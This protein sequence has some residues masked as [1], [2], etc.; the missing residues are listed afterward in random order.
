MSMQQDARVRPSSIKIRVSTGDG[1]DIV[2]SDG[3]AS[4]YDFPYLRDNCPCATCNDERE[5]KEREKAGGLRSD[6]LP[7]YKPKVKANSAAAVGNY[8]IQI[9]FSDSHATGIYSFGFLRGICPCEACRNA[10]RVPGE[11]ASA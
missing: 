4:H 5:R 6:L 1:V 11:R 7:M 8:A 10:S 9:E 3:H 2:W